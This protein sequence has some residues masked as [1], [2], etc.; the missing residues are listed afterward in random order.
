MSVVLLANTVWHDAAQIKPTDSSDVDTTD[1]S[2]AQSVV[3]GQRHLYWAQS[4]TADRKL[5][6]VNKA[7]N[8]N[9][10]HVV[11]ADAI[12]HSGH[13]LKV[14]TYSGY[15]AS[16]T[17]QYDSGSSFSGPYVGKQSKD[18]VYALASRVTNQQAIALSL[19]AGSGGN[20]AKT[21]TKFYACDGLTF[22][23]PGVASY[24]PLA[25]PSRHSYKR[26]FFLVDEEYKLYFDAVS[27]A[28]KETFER[29]PNLMGEP[30]FL[31][32]SAGGLLPDK[33]LHGIITAVEVSARFDD[34]Y[35]I[36]ITLNTLR[37]V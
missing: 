24:R 4:G 26:N 1:T 34:L 23:Y 17:T 35:R 30:V 25:F 6:Y 27:R 10:S 20:W 37:P 31:Y 28:D 15:T 32:D 19:E 14:V 9:C 16:P 33:L 12:N 29:L 21:V 7:G 8:L 18:F 13:T 36:D 5:V 2:T 22:N 3:G 11:V